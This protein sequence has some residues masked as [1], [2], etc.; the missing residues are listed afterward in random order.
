HLG[1]DRLPDAAVLLR[2]VRLHVVEVQVTRP[3]VQPDEDDG[4]LLLRA[5]LLAGLQQPRQPHAGQ[6]GDA[7]L[8]ETAPRQ[9]VAVASDRTEIDAEHEDPPWKEIEPAGGGRASPGHGGRGSELPRL[10]GER[11]SNGSPAVLASGLRAPWRLRPGA[12]SARPQA[13]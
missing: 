10:A 6:A 1:A 7:E 11:D 5:G 3:A 12:G 8:Q 4:R 9:A 13:F 2:G